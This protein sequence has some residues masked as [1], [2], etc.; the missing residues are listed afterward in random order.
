MFAHSENP[1][2]MR[3]EDDKLLAAKHLMADSLLMN[4]KASLSGNLY[5]LLGLQYKK[6]VRRRHAIGIDLRKILS[7]RRECY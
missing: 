4:H 5:A 7:D 1:I 6:V 2:L 3:S